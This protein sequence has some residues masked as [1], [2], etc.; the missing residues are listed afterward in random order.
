MKVRIFLVVVLATLFA[1]TW[2]YGQG[3]NLISWPLILHDTSIQA[4]FA[5]SMGTGCQLTGGVGAP[6]SDK[7]LEYVA[8]TYNTSWYRTTTQAWIGAVT[9]IKPDVAYFVVILGS[10]P[11]VT[12]TMT[13]EVSDTNR[14]IPITPG[15]SFNFVGTCFPVTVPLD[16]TGLIDSGFQG[17]IG[18]PLSDKVIGYDGG[19]QATWYRTSTSAWI[20]TVQQLEPGS[21]Y[22]I[23]VLAGHSFTDNKWIYPVPGGGSKAAKTEVTRKDREQEKP[24]LKKFLRSTAPTTSKRLGAD[25]TVEAKKTR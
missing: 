9:N 18:A 25:K 15:K 21:G 4:A 1:T 23:D 11:A 19:Y 12:L 22:I 20:G 17:G 10:H 3:Y 24:T 5:D 8:G 16:S 6:V 7:V 14:V 2:A 13:G